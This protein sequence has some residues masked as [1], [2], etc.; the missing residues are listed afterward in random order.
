MDGSLTS[1]FYSLLSHEPL[2]QVGQRHLP[3]KNP[4]RCPHIHSLYR[5]F[6]L[7]RLIALSSVLISLQAVLQPLFF[8]NT[9]EI[10]YF[11]QISQSY[12]CIQHIMPICLISHHSIVIMD[13]NGLC[14]GQNCSNHYPRGFPSNTL[15][16]ASVQSSYPFSSF[17]HSV[18]APFVD[19]LTVN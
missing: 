16:S 6:L 7:W 11:L 10:E 14:N 12:S 17:S 13:R 18:I 1:I 2:T 8:L 15:D 5:L 9:L 4:P 19:F 3:F